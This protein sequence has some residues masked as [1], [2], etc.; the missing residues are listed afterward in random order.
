MR[1]KYGTVRSKRTKVVA[2]LKLDISS[3]KKTR[4][5][6]FVLLLAFSLAS[7]TYLQRTRRY[8]PILQPRSRSAGF[9]SGYK[10]G[11]DMPTIAVDKAAL[12]KELGR[13]YAPASRPSGRERSSDSRLGM[14]DILRKNSTSCVSSSV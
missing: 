6:S 8:N 3:Y 10:S 13:E 1:T 12:F 11:S 14:L 4:Q 2:G 5:T 9:V 7:D